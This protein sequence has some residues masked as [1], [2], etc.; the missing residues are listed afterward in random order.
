M[1][2]IKDQ[3]NQNNKI[4]KFFKSKTLETIY[5]NPKFSNDTKLSIMQLNINGLQNKFLEL[6]QLVQENS[7]DIINIQE[8]KLTASSRKF[9]IPGY[10]TIRK[11]REH[12]IGGGLIT[13]IKEEIAFTEINLNKI[14]TTNQFEIL[15]VKINLSEKKHYHV[16]NIYLPP[17]DNNLDSITEDREIEKNFKYLFSLHHHH[18][19]F[20]A[21]RQVLW[22][23][24]LPK[25]PPSSH[26]TLRFSSTHHAFPYWSVKWNYYQ[27]SARR[28]VCTE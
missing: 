18:H 28:Q 2:R 10:T 5:E 23:R 24:T 26:K 1:K 9:N 7:P 14:K 19:W 20:S 27:C 11:D 15:V 21:R 4:P 25:Q 3:N 6:K 8:S 12:K 17:R 16:T 22:H 13:Y